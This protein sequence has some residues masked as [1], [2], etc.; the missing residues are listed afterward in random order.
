MYLFSGNSLKC[1]FNRMYFF[2]LWDS[3][4]G[5]TK[6]KHEHVLSVLLKNFDDVE[7]IDISPLDKRVFNLCK[8]VEKYYKLV[9]CSRS[10]L[11]KKYGDWFSAIECIELTRTDEQC[12]SDLARP[13]TSSGRGRPRKDFSDLSE[14]SK[15]RRL[16]ELSEVDDSAVSA[17]LSSSKVSETPLTTNISADEVLSLF[18]EAKLTKHQYLLI[19]NFINSKMS[20]KVLPSYQSVLQAKKKCYPSDMVVTESKAEI[21]LQSLLDH[22]ASRILESEKSVLDSLPVESD[23]L[24]LIGKWGFDGSTGHSEYKQSF[25]NSSLDDSSLFVTSYVPLQVVNNSDNK[26]LWKNPRPSSTR[27]CRPIRFQFVK[28]S[29]T[30]SKNEESYFKE[31]IASLCPTTFS[32]N[33]RNRI[34]KIQHTL[35]LTMVDGKICSALSETS[36]ARCYICEATPKEMNDIDRCLQ[37]Q[38]DENRFE[39]GLSPLHSWMRFFEYFLHLSYRIDIKKWQVRSDD[40]KKLLADK[41]LHV[42]NEFRSRLGLIVDKPRSGGSGTSNDGNT[43]RKFFLNSAASAEITGLSKDLIDRCSTILQALSSGYNINVASFSNFSLETA[44][45]LVQ[46][47][48]WYNL[49]ASVHKVLLHGSDVIKYGLVSIGELSEEAAEA[50]NKN[51]KAFRRDHTRKM[52]RKVTN[53][54]LMNRLM[55]HSDP[56]V[57]SLRKL[58]RKKKSIFS[59]QVLSLL[60]V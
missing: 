3:V 13:S 38:S 40:D 27:Y 44:K 49:P 11:F 19:M 43:A 45:L 55:L 34:F 10:K 37:K 20:C 30:V 47:Y 18:V 4:K 39:F 58:P 50:N 42:Q 14:R 29:S 15:R 35:Q 21:E 26:I 16:T 9:N 46:E 1:S 41:K 56:F 7:N 57:T 53:I 54:D 36:S 5:Y 48:P 60:S 31:K 33:D 24:T 2:E 28:E 59:S 23:N 17:L 8:S 51:L 25:A 52:S 32:F 12:P 6:A 22:T